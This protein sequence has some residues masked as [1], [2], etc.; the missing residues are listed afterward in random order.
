MTTRV[1][2]LK[3]SLAAGAMLAG[4]LVINSTVNY[5]RAAARVEENHTRRQLTQHAMQL[6][7]AVRKEKSAAGL[8][9]LIDDFH[10]DRAGRIAWIRIF[11]REGKLVTSAGESGGLSFPLDKVEEKLRARATMSEVRRRGDERILVEAQP[12][13]GAPPIEVDDPRRT[14]LLEMGLF[15][16]VD[17]GVLWPLR[18][19]LLVTYLGGGALLGALALI[20]L[21]FRAYAN[22]RSLEQ[23]VEI[24]SQVQQDLFPKAFRLPANLDMA[25]S[26]VAAWQI[27]GDF[28]D[29]FDIPG[30]RS[31]VV[32]G[33]VSGKGIPAALLMGVIHG[34]VRSSRWAEGEGH[35]GSLAMHLNRLLYEHSSGE[36][37]ATM[38]WCDF[39][40][41][42]RELEYVNAGHCPPML[43]SNQDSK[44]RVA[45]LREGGPVLG[46]LPHARYG[47]GTV[48]LGPDDCLVLYSDGIE[49]AVNDAGAEFGQDRLERILVANAGL[50]AEEI[51]S[52]VF[53][54][55]RDFAGAARAVDDL[56]LV[57]V[58]PL[59]VGAGMPVAA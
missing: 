3:L 29:A 19:N 27:G 58:K 50:A 16:E 7:A 59:P 5:R 11:D 17:D 53:E 42:T 51:R 31:A 55:V 47:R 15:V 44:P 38:F 2:G 22:G 12:L 4:V 43:I 40:P 9:A 52:A 20:G 13:R 48:R 39:D 18:W 14:L 56:T 8:A 23:Q 1:L 54:A 35:A 6:E 46:L 49:D 24:A 41:D 37:Y 30:G 33:D 28:Y 34:A 45:R 26:S 57:V 10:K 32:L 36:R 21:R 25:A